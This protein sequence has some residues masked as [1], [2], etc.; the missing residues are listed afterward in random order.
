MKV[1]KFVRDLL[2]HYEGK[3]EPFNE[4]EVYDALGNARKSCPDL[5]EEEFRGFRA[6]ASAFFFHERRHRDSVWGTY[7]APMFTGTT[8][9]GTQVHSPDIRELNPEVT[10]YWEERAK[11]CKHPVLRARYADLV[12][13]LTQS[14]TGQRPNV[15][16]ARLAIDSYLEATDRAFYTIAIHGI[17]WCE[18]ALDLA[19]SISDKGKAQFV[20][21]FMFRLFD[22]VVNPAHIGT[23]L[24]LFDNL[25]GRRDLISSEQELEIVLRLERILATV[26]DRSAGESFNPWG[27]EAA[28]ERLQKHF[29]REGKPGD[30]ERVVRTYGQAFETV[31]GD[32]EHVS[33]A[34][35]DNGAFLSGLRLLR[36]GGVLATD[37]GRNDENALLAFLHESSELVPSVKA[38]D[39]GS[40]RLLRRNQH[41]V[42][43]AIAVELGHCIQ[44][45][46]E[47]FAAAFVERSD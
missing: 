43:Q 24:F 6:E 25:Y 4:V 28:A 2:E 44:V 18:R 17:R 20:A 35:G 7:F 40:S 36:L 11:K 15:E 5:T 33:T 34:K 22:R 47:S 26:S 21:G 16:F 12:W 13:D 27:A 23:W 8:S 14:I 38:C 1:P 41:D 45:A 10:A 19:L 46:G 9:D 31:A 39:M 37:N 30:V 3:T 29:E 32:V 42:S